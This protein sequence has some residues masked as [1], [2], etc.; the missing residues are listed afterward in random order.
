MFMGYYLFFCGL[1]T[2]F[3][4]DRVG[5]RGVALLKRQFSKIVVKTRGV[6]AQQLNGGLF[7]ISA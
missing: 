5:Q 4:G 3:V 1:T 6:R 2:K 7:G